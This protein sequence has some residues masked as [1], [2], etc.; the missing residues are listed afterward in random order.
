MAMPRYS[1]LAAAWTDDRVDRIACAYFE[2]DV[3][4]ESIDFIIILL[5]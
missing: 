5:Y 4:S 2:L 3:S 1:Q